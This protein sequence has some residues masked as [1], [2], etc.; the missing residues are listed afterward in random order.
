MKIIH[1]AGKRKR[2]I[3]RATL[4]DGKGIIKINKIPIDCIESKLARMKLQEALL[5][6][7]DATKKVDINVRV[8]GGGINGQAEASR[9]A[10][11]RTL[12]EFDKKLQK[13]FIEYDRQLLVPDVRQKETR[14]PNTAGNARSKVQKSYR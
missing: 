7:G 12:V 8:S 14:K 2:S 1:K 13:A 5:I 9:V 11:C 10:I 4:K 3:A 6:A